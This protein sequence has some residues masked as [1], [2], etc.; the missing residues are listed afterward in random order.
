MS[1]GPRISFL[2][3]AT[4][5]MRFVLVDSCGGVHMNLLEFCDANGIEVSNLTRE[6]FTRRFNG[7]PWRVV[8]SE[9]EIDGGSARKALRRMAERA[10]QI[11]YAPEHDMTKIAAPGFSVKG[12]STYYDE[13]GRPRGQWVKTQ[14][15]RNNP[16]VLMELMREA[17]KDWKGLGKRI[18][19]P[20]ATSTRRSVVIPLGDPHLGMLSWAPETGQDFDLKIAKAQLEE[21]VARLVETCPPCSE[22]VILNLGDFFHA[23]DDSSSTKQSKN[24]LDTDGR[25]SK[26]YLAGLHAMKSC[27]DHA[28]RHHKKVIV[29]NLIGNHDDK[30]SWVLGVSLDSFFHNDPRVHVD[31]SPAMIW[32]YQFHRVMVAATHGHT[33]KPSEIGGV[34]ANDKPQMWAETHHRYALFGHVHHSSKGI[35]NESPGVKWETF[36]TLAARDAWH[37]AQAYRSGRD[38]YAIVMDRDHGETER[39]RVDVSMLENK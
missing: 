20:K 11:G 34:M 37:A 17:A 9:L 15:D 24:P 16:D 10:A 21:A 29:K 6:I 4:W 39:H 5:Y 38:M 27:I 26:V 13:T 22:C 3:G 33:I 18:K 28:R 32:Y 14:R 36:R 35:A 30:T 31:I 19:A 25:W 8:E 1:H 7:Q 2:R 12:T 23:H